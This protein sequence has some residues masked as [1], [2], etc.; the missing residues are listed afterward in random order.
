M[1]STPIANPE[2]CDPPSC[3]RLDA[4]PAA[5]ETAAYPELYLGC[6]SLSWGV[7]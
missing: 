4:R 3:A 6:R 5:L 7:G 2:R 1:R